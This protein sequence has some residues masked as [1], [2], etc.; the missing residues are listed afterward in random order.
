MKERVKA[1]LIGE[2][3]VPRFNNIKKVLPEVIRLKGICD[4]ASF[5]HKESK[6]MQECT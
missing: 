1:S 4:A 2:S 6:A 3:K 5:V